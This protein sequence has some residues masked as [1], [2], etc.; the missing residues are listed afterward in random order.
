MILHHPGLVDS[1]VGSSDSSYTSSIYSFSLNFLSTFFL[2]G[3]G[4]S[5]LSLSK[6]LKIS[7][8]LSLSDSVSQSLRSIY[9]SH[10]SNNLTS[11]LSLKMR[12]VAKNCRYGLYFSLLQQQELPDSLTASSSMS[13]SSKKNISLGSLWSSYSCT[14]L[15]MIFY[16]SYST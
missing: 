16:S 8:S 11:S 1:S 4:V 14:S 9:A 10:C 12:A 2:T 6:A 3:F 13:I 5:S 7:S 15:Y